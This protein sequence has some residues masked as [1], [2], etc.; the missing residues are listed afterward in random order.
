MQKGIVPMKKI[1]LL[2]LDERPCNFEFPYKIFNSADME[3]VRPAKLGDKKIPAEFE[4]IKS[5]LLKNAAEADAAVISV[6][7][8]LYGG[9]IPSRL[10]HLE[11]LEADRRLDVIR[12]MKR[13]NPQIKLYVF[14][15]I[16]RCPSYSSADEEPDYYETCGAEIHQLGKFTH[17]NSLSMCGADEMDELTK[18]VPN[19]FLEDYKNRRKFNLDYNIKTLDMVEDGTVEVLVI[20]QD[21]SAPYGFTAIDQKTVRNAINEKLLNDKV[22]MYPGADE[23]AMTLLSR[24][25]NDLN[26]RRPMV[27]LRYASVKAPF[28]IPNYEDRS[29]G[30]TVKYHLMSAGCVVTE[31]L[32]KADFA[33]CITAP[34]DKMEEADL[35]PAC[36]IQY[37]VE[38]NLTEMLWFMDKCLADGIP[39]ALLDNAYVNGGEIALLKLLNKK[40]MLLKLI[41]YAGWNTSANSMGTVIAQAVHYLYYG[42]CR[43]HYDFLVE[44]YLE[45]VGYC[46]VIR[47][48]TTVNELPSMGMSYF[49]VK[50]QRGVV[51]R[52]VQDKLNRFKD[53]Y[54]TAIAKDIEVTDVYMPW[55]RMFEVG[56]SAKYK[57][58][59]E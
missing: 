12:E 4:D 45:D 8:L 5:F 24:V 52:M 1:L 50:E 57:G 38:R 39:V 13:L 30:E 42:K 25:L 3:I 29:L 19:D 47:G 28:L 35:Q 6:D 15:C 10:H 26:G 51:A 32:S 20:P 14:Q 17:M 53:E 59:I 23:V 11:A 54:L 27:Y 18:K 37:D 34:A 44:R 9:L 22:L 31:E 48:S 55:S 16:M 49:D 33:L 7:T 41:A 46:S 2:P 43:A 21:D 36:N 56:I 58:D 40:D